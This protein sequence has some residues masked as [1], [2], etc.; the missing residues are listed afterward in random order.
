MKRLLLSSAL[1]LCAAVPVLTGC[2]LNAPASGGPPASQS[3]TATPGT[4]GQKPHPVSASALISPPKGKYLG[5]EAYGL[6]GSLT[7]LI[8]VAASIG[9]RPNL[10]GQYVAWG[11]PFDGAGALQAW[12][13]GALYYMAWEPYT[14]S[15]HDIAAG[16]SDSYIRR[17][18]QAVRAFGLPVAISFGHEMNGNWYPWGSEATPA[19]TFVAAW[20]HIHNLFQAA[21]ATNVIWVWNPNVINAAPGVALRPYWPGSNYVNWVGLTGYFGLTGPDTF[22]GV[23]GPTMRQIRE[24]TGKPFIIAET[25]VQSGPN[26]AT[27][28]QS[29]VHAVAARADVLG[30]IWFDYDKD[31]IDWRIE[32]RPPVRAELAGSVANMPLVR[33]D[34]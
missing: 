33:I 1:M 30:F 15:V 29:L 21:G 27:C 25:A 16:S 23:F 26:A 19:A 9:R 4:S 11:T 18:A 32:S 24:F 34:S 2:G 28:A 12:G 10:A 3:Q 8:N 14:T 22:S 17:F 31:G 7:P 20:R 13:Y 6:P 5:I